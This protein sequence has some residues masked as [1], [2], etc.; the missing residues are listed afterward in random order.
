VHASISAKLES[1]DEWT[2]RSALE[3]ALFLEDAISQNKFHTHTKK[4]CWISR[5]FNE[6]GM[7][8][9]LLMG[10]RDRQIS[11]SSRAVWSTQGVSG[12]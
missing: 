12:Q 10:G 11:V 5:S 8:F 4:D 3:I 9:T 6:K 2:N 1:V 7:C